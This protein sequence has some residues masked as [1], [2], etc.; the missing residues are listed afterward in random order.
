MIAGA[1]VIVV[2]RWQVSGD[3]DQVLDIVAR[4]RSA[5]LAEPGC[6]SYEAY[7]AVDA[8]DTV[9]LVEQ[10]RDSEA[11]YEHRASPHYQREVLEGVLPL[12]LA[13]QVQ[14]LHPHDAHAAAPQPTVPPTP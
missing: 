11:L 10:Y 7:R 13:R 9:L 12:L 6:L 2:A 1:P 3:V 14:I 8:P 5:S 4:L